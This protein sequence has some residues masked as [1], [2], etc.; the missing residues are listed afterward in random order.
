MCYRPQQGSEMR[1]LYA[2]K[3]ARTVPGR[4]EGG[5][6]LSLFDRINMELKRRTK[7]I[8]V[9]PNEESLLWLVGSILMDINEEWVT[10]RRHLT[11]EKE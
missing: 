11:M 2:V 3:V 10:G 8:G 7:V 9:F 4:G 5:N 1:E 6:A